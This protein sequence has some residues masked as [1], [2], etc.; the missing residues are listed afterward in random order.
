[1]AKLRFI[2]DAAEQRKAI[3]VSF[4]L[5]DFSDFC[6]QP[7]ASAAIPRLTDKMFEVLEHFFAGDIDRFLF[8]VRDGIARL[9]EPDMIK[10]TG[11]GALLT[12]T[13]PVSEDFDTEFCEGVIQNMR[14]YQ[15]ALQE[16][17]KRSEKEWR[18]SRLPKRVKVGIATGI[19][20]GLKEQALLAP[21]VPVD[22]VGYCVNLAV[23][24]QNYVPELGFLVHGSLHPQLQQMTRMR[25][26]KLKGSQIED[27]FVFEEDLRRV[28]KSVL[29]RKFVAV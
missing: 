15:Q 10:F 6:K 7:D 26:T 8:P 20:Y 12:W 17:L 22:F 27:V 11:D 19:V 28:P 18:V 1:M 9:P 21:I 24:L 25:A 23:R 29:V 3:V 4:D 2:K 5:S 13:R 16:E 14:S